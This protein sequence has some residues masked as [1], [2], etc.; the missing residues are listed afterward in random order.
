MDEK[1]ARY[2]EQV[3][4]W[5]EVMEAHALPDWEDFPELELYMDQVVILASQ[6]MSHLG[7][8]LGEDKPV[9]PA[10]INNYVKMGLLAPPVK[11]RYR[12]THLACLVMICVLKRSLTMAAIQRLM[13]PGMDEAEIERLYRAFRRNR[14]RG[15]EYVAKHVHEGDGEIFHSEPEEDDRAF[16]IRLAVMANLFKISAEKLT[17]AEPESKKK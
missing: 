10:M 7:P 3:T 8:M 15:I 11:K 13:P 12:R 6:Y 4:E 17:G 1:E 2:R 9:T 5:A 16:I 14:S